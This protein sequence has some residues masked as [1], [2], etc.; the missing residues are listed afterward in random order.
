MNPHICKGDGECV[1]TEGS[2]TCNCPP[3]LT[4]DP[5]GTKCLDNREEPCYLDYRANACSKPMKGVFKHDA[6]CCSVGKA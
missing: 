2:F 1:N 3:G 4:L 5:T 6:C